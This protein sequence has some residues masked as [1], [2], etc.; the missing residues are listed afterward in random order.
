MTEYGVCAIQVRCA[1]YG[2]VCSNLLRSEHE[3]FFFLV[4]GSSLCFEAILESQ[5]AGFIVCLTHL[6]DFL[7]VLAGQ[8]VEDFVDAVVVL[9][10]GH[11]EQLCFAELASGYDVKLAT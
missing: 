6:V 3:R 9:L 8:F 4:L 2:S 7:H 5:Q 10:S 1:T 11:V